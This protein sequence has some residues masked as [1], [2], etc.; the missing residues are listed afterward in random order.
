MS[1]RVAFRGMRFLTL[2][3]RMRMEGSSV[4]WS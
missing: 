4:L 3:A 1:A 2:G